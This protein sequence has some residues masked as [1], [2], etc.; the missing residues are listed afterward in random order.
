MFLEYPVSCRQ[1]VYSTVLQRAHSAI[2]G[3]LRFVS[4]QNEIQSSLGKPRFKS[5]LSHVPLFNTL[6][7]N[8]FTAQNL[9][10]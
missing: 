7:L 1:M 8:N 2:C 5:P 9:C 4:A 6:F 10:C 3:K